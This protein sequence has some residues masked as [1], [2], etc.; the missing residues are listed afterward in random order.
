MKA[1]PVLDEHDAPAAAADRPGRGPT[2]SGHPPARAR[3]ELIATKPGDVRSWDITRLHGPQRGVYYDLHVI[4]DINSRYVVG[5]TIAAHTPASVHCGTAALLHQQRRQ[6]LHAAYPANPA[7][8]R[9]RR[10]EPPTLT[11]AAWINQPNREALIQN[12]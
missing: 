9:H 5:W 8:Y 3:P 7:R 11:T 4:L 12:N 10:P 1:S 2:R 6:T